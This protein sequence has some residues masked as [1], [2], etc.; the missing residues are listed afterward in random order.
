MWLLSKYH[1]M[2][3]L[4]CENVNTLKTLLLVVLRLRKCEY[5]QNITRCGA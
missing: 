2:W 5:S 4:D 3:R 1:A